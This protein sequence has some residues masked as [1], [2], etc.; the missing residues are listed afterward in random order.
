M[1][2]LTAECIRSKSTYVVCRFVSDD[3]KDAIAAALPTL[4]TLVWMK[5]S[6][7]GTELRCSAR[8]SAASDAPYFGAVSK[9]R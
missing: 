4:P 5:T 8:P 2:P 3:S 6:E 7:R 9:R 1:Q